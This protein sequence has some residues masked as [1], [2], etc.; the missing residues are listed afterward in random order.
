MG[1]LPFSVNNY[2][3]ALAS[4]ADTLNISEFQS[5]IDLIKSKFELGKKIITCGNGG[6]A[7]TASHYLS[8]I[9]I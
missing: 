4:L 6:S 1:V 3:D 2:V 9:H 7:Y 5:G 8:L